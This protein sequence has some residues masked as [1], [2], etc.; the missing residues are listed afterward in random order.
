MAY[1]PKEKSNIIVNMVAELN[2]VLQG[3]YF[4]VT[5]CELGGQVRYSLNFTSLGL[6]KKKYLYLTTHEGFSLNYKQMVS[7]MQG[8][9]VGLRAGLEKNDIASY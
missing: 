7:Y 1:F 8:I 5:K 2:H 9:L 3:Q 6:K 4:T